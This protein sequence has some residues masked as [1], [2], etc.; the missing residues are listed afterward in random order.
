MQVDVY[1]IHWPDPTLDLADMLAGIN[2]AYEAGYFKRFGLSNFSAVDVEKA[3]DICRTNNYVLPSVY[4]GSYS[5]VSRLVETKLFPTLRR[6]GIAFYAYSPLAGGLL[7]KSKE[8]LIAR[9]EDAGRFGQGHWIGKTYD[10][11][12]NKPSYHTA[13][14]MWA[15]AASMAGCTKAEL[16]LRW[17]AFDSALDAK[18]GDAIVFGASRVDQAETSLQWFKTGSVGED[19][20][21]LVE[22]IWQVVEKDAPHDC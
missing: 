14:D 22:K 20:K 4:Q 6:L 2:S 1:Y 16:A 9:S 11:L 17:I 12:Y 15:E 18:Y 13:L 5:A 21:K 10:D 19:A 3:Y 8:Q 7:T